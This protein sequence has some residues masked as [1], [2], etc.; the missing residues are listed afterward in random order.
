VSEL[1]L[2][3]H[4]ETEW[5][6]ALKHT[7]RTDIPLTGAG[8]EQARLVGRALVGREF[9]RV[10]SSPL[11]R[12]LDTCRLALPGGEPEV[13]P[14][15]AEWDYGDYEG[16]TTAEIRKIVPEWTIW[17][18]G[19]AGGES[20]ADVRERVDRLV[21]GLRHE[22]AD[23]AV[24]SHGHLLRALTARWLELE[25]AEGRRFVLDTG[26]ISVLGYE[27]DTPAVRR[28]NEPV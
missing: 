7:G 9:G 10:L 2:V 3:R 25:P 11:R 19:A 27:R 28:W 22:Q 21:A 16:I 20:V 15:L 1:V 12:A 18:H 24:F 4:G 5:S 26:T 23:V 13:R 6:R 8:E 17:T 14:E